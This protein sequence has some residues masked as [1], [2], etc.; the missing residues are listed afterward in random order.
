MVEVDKS[1]VGIKIRFKDTRGKNVECTIVDIKPGNPLTNIKTEKVNDNTAK[2]KLKPVN[3][4]K[5]FWT[6]T[7][8]KCE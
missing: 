2:L 5:A 8:N 4:S 3:G 7:M 6:K 1:D